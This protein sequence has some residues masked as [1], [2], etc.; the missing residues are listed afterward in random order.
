MTNIAFLNDIIRDTYYVVM[1]RKKN[2]NH[3]KLEI[4]RRFLKVKYNITIGMESLKRRDKEYKEQS[5][6]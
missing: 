1:R 5:K 2:S 3:D 4:L 6:G